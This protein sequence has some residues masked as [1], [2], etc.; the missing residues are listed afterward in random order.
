MNEPVSKRVLERIEKAFLYN[1]DVLYLPGTE[2]TYIPEELCKLEHL[3]KL[4]L[5]NNQIEKIPEHLTRLTNLTEL[6]LG[7]NQLKEIPEHLTRLTNLTSLYI[8]N[9]HLQEIPEH[10]TRLTNLTMLYLRG[11]ELKEIP[12]HITR[13]TNLIMLDLRGNELQEIPEH[14]TRLTNL[15]SLYLGGNKLQEISE[16]ITRLTNLTV[17]DLS[18]NEL[19]EI[20]E[21]VLEF[22]KLRYLWVNNNPIEN[23]PPEILRKDF[24]EIKEYL[25][26]LEG[27]KKA[28]DEV[29][30]LLVGDG[31]AG[32][33]SLIKQV[34]GE[35]FNPAESK[36][37]GIN[38][39]NWDTGN[40]E[41]EIKVKFWDF[42]GQDIMHATHKFFLSK[43]SFYV[44]VLNAREKDSSE[45]WLQLIESFGGN[46]PILVVINKIDENPSFDL[47]RKFL[48]KKYKGIKGFHR[49]CCVDG[50]GV[51][52]F[53]SDLAKKL[54]ETEFM[55]TTWPLYWF[56]VKN[57]LE[58]MKDNYI[59]Y[60]KYKNICQEEKVTRAKSQESL[61]DFLNDLGV[62]LH[63]NELDLDDTHVLEPKWV[64]E[65]VYKIINSEKL[66]LNHGLLKLSDLKEILAKKKDDRYT[67]P[68]KMHKYIV[69]LMKKFELCYSINPEE[70]LVPDL[71][72]VQEKDFTFDYDSALRFVIEYD[73]LPRSIMPQFIVRMHEEIKDDLRWRTGVVL[74]NNAY[75]STAVVKLDYV[76]KKIFIYVQGQLKKEYLSVIRHKFLAINSSYEKIGAMEMVPCICSVCQKS[77]EPEYRKYETLIRFRAKPIKKVHCSKS[78]EPV[79]VEE[80]LEGIEKK[81]FSSEEEILEILRELRDKS[82]SKESF[83]EEASKIVEI[84]L[85]MFGVNIDLMA[86]AKKWF[87]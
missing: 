57:R 29:K 22:K 35:K 10:I 83:L 87:K 9:N 33:T 72:E 76:A 48:Q 12:E 49:V 19:Q 25:R 2:L 20:P 86:L 68:R 74:E 31:G 70:I 37:H 51:E 39:Q 44:L 50:T 64:T 80:L 59:D 77:P 52:G 63:F 11:N 54:P 17:L 1:K 30:V 67:Y 46:S 61:V 4:D 65:A 24:S 13:L 81:G 18:Y 62:I 34:F 21:S 69:N 42:G 82:E 47:N 3:K 60:D 84:K 73:F 23:I 28:L 40:E 55:Q 79:L 56:N 58:G 66:A 78:A 32:K 45:Y 43:R 15:T 41:R 85:G 38:I 16:H 36:T 6:N 71:L 14:I 27:E 26:S 53:R 5:R 8:G 7:S 75:S